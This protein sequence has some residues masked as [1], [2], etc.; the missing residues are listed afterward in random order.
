VTRWRIWLV[1]GVATLAASAPAQASDPGTWVRTAQLFEPA[2]YRQGL[3]SNPATGEVFF[4][5]S[6]AGIY[7]TRSGKE[8]AQNTAPIPPDVAQREQYNHIG[9]IAFDSLEGGRLLLPLESY[10]PFQPDQN[11]SKTGAAG[12]MDPA[13]LRW[14]YYVKLDPAEIPKAMMFATDEANGIVW[15]PVGKDLLAYNLSDINPANAAPDGP[16]IHSVRR[17]V[18]VVPDGVGGAVVFGG[19]IY[20]S[21]SAN[22]VEHVDSVDANTGASRVEIEMPGDLEAEGMDVGPYLGGFLHWQLVPGLSATQLFNFVPTGSTL[23][24]RLNHARVRAG[25]KSV[26]TATVTVVANGNVI[27][28]PGAQVRLAGRI[29]KTNAAGIAKLKVKP[30]RGGYRAQAFLKGLRTASKK[31]RAI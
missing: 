9:D 25:K 28:L 21:A 16:V 7:R 1:A 20:F 11:P 30:A 12:V 4:S 18:G 3:A 17:L 31:F 2:Y 13:T 23:R 22:G 29:A 15:T 14:K 8:L 5:G 24:L 19:R 26:I 6:S 27:P 10:A